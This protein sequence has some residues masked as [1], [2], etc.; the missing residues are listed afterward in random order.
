MFNSERTLVMGVINTTPD[1]FSDGGINFNHDD[2]ISTGLKMIVDGADILDIGGES[3]RPGSSFVDVQEELSRVMPVIKGIMQENRDC[4]VSIDTRRRLV[5]EAAIKEGVRIINDVTGFRHDPTL[6]DFGRE[7]GTGMIIMHMLGT[8]RDMQ[9]NINYLNFPQDI[10][11][12]FV[13][14]INELETRG[15]E[16]DRIVVDPGIGFGKTFDHNLILLNRIDFFSTLNKPILIGAS[17][18]AFLGKILNEPDP[19][20]RGVGT[21]ATVAMSVMKGASIVRVHD[22]LPAVQMCRV[23]EAIL[24]ETVEP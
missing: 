9:T 11:D 14:R 10:H 8:P 7:A 19:M 24:R 6:V 20:K 23:T 4:V 16:P 12:F 22:V 15:I 21:L 5:A 13:E 18:K 3:T 1:S 2:A 17:R